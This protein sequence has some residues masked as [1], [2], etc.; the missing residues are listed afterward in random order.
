M[1]AKR[2]ILGS[3]VVRAMTGIGANKSLIRSQADV[4]FAT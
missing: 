3:I 2:E 4:G 1:T